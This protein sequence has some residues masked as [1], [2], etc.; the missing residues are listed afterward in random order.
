ME[1]QS[2]GENR[3]SGIVFAENKD[4]S[5]N[6][7]ELTIREVKEFMMRITKENIFLKKKLKEYM[8]KENTIDFGD[9]S[10]TIIS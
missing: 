7:K 4:E 5:T 1:R 8:E 10:N 6:R 9:I 3:P 2:L